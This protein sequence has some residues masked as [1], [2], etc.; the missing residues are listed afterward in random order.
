MGSRRCDIAIGYRQ[1][2]MHIIKHPM[3]L[4][5]TRC[6]IGNRR[7]FIYKISTLSHS[8]R[9]DAISQSVISNIPC[10]II[11]RL[12]STPDAM[13]FRYRRLGVCY[14]YVY[15]TPILPMRCDIAIGDR[16]FEKCQY[17]KLS[18]PDARLR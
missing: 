13:R 17:K 2:S 14:P 10:I 11:R 9:S 1:N 3:P 4:V 16:S 5:P 7:Y 6:A 12:D 15:I 8:P 18:L